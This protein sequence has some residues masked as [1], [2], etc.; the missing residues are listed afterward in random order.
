MDQAFQYQLTYFFDGGQPY[1]SL[2]LD[3][4]GNIL[5]DRIYLYDEQGKQIDTPYLELE[6]RTMEGHWVNDS[7]APNGDWLVRRKIV[8]DTLSE[9]QIREFYYDDDAFQNEVFYPAILSTKKFSENVFSF[10][11]EERLLFQTK[12]LDWENQFGYLSVKKDGLYTE[13]KLIEALDTFYNGAI[14]P[15]GDQIIYTLRKKDG[16]RLFL[17]K[18][19]EDGWTEKIEILSTPELQGGYFYWLTDTELFFYTPKNNGDLIQGKLVSDR[20]VITDELAALNT[21]KGTEFSPF[22]D[23]DRQF[24]I[25]ARYLEGE[26]SQQ[27]FFISFYLRA[28]GPSKWSRPQKINALPYG[29]N[30]YIT[31]DGRRFLYTDGE[32]IQCVPMKDLKLDQM[33]PN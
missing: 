24:I 4:L 31:K 8:Q 27:G 22:V 10:A 6:A 14:N 19:Q 7:L 25:F 13:P 9:W 21:S 28:R 32:N 23:R 1:R 15:S 12:T 16:E 30:P 33:K 2:E 26:E 17:L 5:K 3:S 29:W 20:L 11:Q 18:K